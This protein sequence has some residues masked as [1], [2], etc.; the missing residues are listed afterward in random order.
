MAWPNQE[1]EC[2]LAN[3]IARHLPP[4]TI[5][6]LSSVGFRRKMETCYES[7]LSQKSSSSHRNRVASTLRAEVLPTV[8][9]SWPRIEEFPACTVERRQYL[10]LQS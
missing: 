5:N 8:M 10:S 7:Q 4:R 9:S 2:L 6:P 1:R 3:Q